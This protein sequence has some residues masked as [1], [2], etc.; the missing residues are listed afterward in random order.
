MGSAHWCGPPRAI[1][2]V[3]AKVP[4]FHLPKYEYPRH[5]QRRFLHSPSN[6]HQLLVF[7]HRRVHLPILDPKTSFCLVVKGKF[8]RRAFRGSPDN[9][10]NYV[11]SVA[12]DAGTAF[13]ALFIFLV[14]DLPN[15]RIDWWGNTVYQNSEHCFTM[16]RAELTDSGGLERSGSVVV[17]CTANRLRA[18]RVVNSLKVAFELGAFMW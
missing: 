15:A 3:G 12:L 14:L 8:R 18:G 6:R 17:R 11:L 1:V 4:S 9:Q 13:S 5:H 7:L 10:Y 16:R 2:V